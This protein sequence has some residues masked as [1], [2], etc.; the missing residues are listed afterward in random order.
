ML[1]HE[2]ARRKAGQSFGELALLY[3]SPR[4]A[5]V[6]AV[7]ITHLAVLTKADYD[8]IIK[9]L[10]VKDLKQRVETLKICPMFSHWTKM[11]LSKLA[12]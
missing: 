5:S 6:Q 2:V 8:E 1:T 10:D 11:S 3:N 4:S 7:R 12:Y 9:N